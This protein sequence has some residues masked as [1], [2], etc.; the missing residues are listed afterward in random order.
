MEDWFHPRHLARSTNPR[1]PIR[2]MSA[3]GLLRFALLRFGGEELRGFCEV[4]KCKRI[5][6]VKKKIDV[7]D[8]A[9]KKL[10]L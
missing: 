10:I 2:P 6:A 8:L 5:P 1:R 3:A 9:D 7:L 4:F